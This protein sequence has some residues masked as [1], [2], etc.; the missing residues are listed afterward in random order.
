MK[1]LL[2]ITLTLAALTPSVS[3]ESIQ[4]ISLTKVIAASVEKAI[5]KIE[6][7]TCETVK[8]YT[9]ESRKTLKKVKQNM[10][11][12]NVAMEE[13]LMYEENTLMHLNDL[14]AIGDIE[15]VKAIEIANLQEF[16]TSENYMF[17]NT[18]LALKLSKRGYLGG[19][20]AIIPDFI[21]DLITLP[22]TFIASLMTG[23]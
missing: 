20:L 23:F 15:V 12:N 5:A 17:E 19:T 9:D 4:K 8:C 10:L 16:Q 1:K 3:A 18:I 13:V 2:L 11:D 14:D 6:S 7:N 21:F 22:A